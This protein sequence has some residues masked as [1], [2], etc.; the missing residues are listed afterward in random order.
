MGVRD[1]DSTSY[2]LIEASRTVSFQKVPP[3]W[4]FLSYDLAT[5]NES[6]N[7]S[8]ETNLSNMVV[9]EKKEPFKLVQDPRREQLPAS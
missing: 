8:F 3:W 7:L 4:P 5:P 1:E 2:S 6:K 9:H